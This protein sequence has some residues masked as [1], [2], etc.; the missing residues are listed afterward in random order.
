MKAKIILLAL[1]FLHL[2]SFSQVKTITTDLIA[3]NSFQLSLN[4][5]VAI[6]KDTT[7]ANKRDNYL[8]TEKAAK[9]YSNKYRYVFGTGFTYNGDTVNASG[10]GGGSTYS[11]LT[12]VNL[13]SLANKQVPV[14]NSTLGKW[15]NKDVLQFSI[16]GLLNNDLLQYNGSTGLWE[17]KPPTVAATGWAITGNASTTA[18]TNFIGTT[19]NVNVVFKR[20]GIVAGLLDSALHKT[21]CGVMSGNGL[22][23]TGLDNTVVGYYAGRKFT[24]ANYNTVI[25]S[26]AFQN[27]LIADYNIAIGYNSLF[28]AATGSNMAIGVQALYS[29]TAGSSNIGI[30]FNSLYFEGTG[31]NNTALGHTALNGNANFS[32]MVGIG[33]G[34]AGTGGNSV[35]VG[36]S[37]NT[38]SGIE[39]TAIGY[40]AKAGSTGS[41]NIGIGS[42][43]LTSTTSGQVNVAIG[44]NAMTNNI[45]GSRNVVI[46][47]QA[48]Q[49]YGTSTPSLTRIDS[50]VL[51][52]SITKPNADNETNEIVIAGHS[53]LGIGS[54][55]TSIGNTSTLK[56][57]QYGQLSSVT[58]NIYPAAT[59]AQLEIISTTKTFLPPRM[60][61]TQRNAIVFSTQLRDISLVFGTGYT[62]GTYSITFS[63]G[64]GTGAAGTVTVSSGGYFS[65]TISNYGSGYTSAPTASISAGA[66]SGGSITVTIP[67]LKGSTIYCTDCTATDASTGVMQTWNGSA[68]KNNW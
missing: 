43:V 37:S 16:A 20:N 46:G 54:N 48:G 40:L 49:Y 8:I 15:E 45:L 24:T 65:Y 2:I 10:G 68:W 14:Y 26:N 38:G 47:G 42:Q 29:K 44:L 36:Y 3:K 33:F 35:A 50:S 63:G 19:D 61:Q 67:E 56:N 5:V 4:K 31:S 17:N 25:G 64:G 6:S 1:L 11:G 39:N 7:D 18:G 57:I 30:G 13:V 28:T 34:A 52:G 66:G 41:Y 23:S 9:D 60:T 58:G 53:G 51:I 32:N 22:T 59:P 55:S 21:L 62:N 12:D 27:N